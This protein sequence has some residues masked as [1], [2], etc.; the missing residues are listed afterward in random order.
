MVDVL[1]QEKPVARK[2]HRCLFCG[3]VIKKGEK[4]QHNVYVTDGE[5]DDQRMHLCCEDA[6]AEFFDPYDDYLD[7]DAIMEGVNDAL[8][9]AG[10]EPAK[11]VYEAVLQWKDLQSKTE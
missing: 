8:H 10:I 7:V 3:A 6:V 9:D 11:T 4:Y 1:R 5:I 2:E